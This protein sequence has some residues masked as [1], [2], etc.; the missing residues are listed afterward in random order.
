M[1]GAAAVVAGLAAIVVAVVAM[2]GGDDSPGAGTGTGNPSAG[3]PRSP[4][5]AG[6]GGD[7]L[8]RRVRERKQVRAPAFSLA[9]I[10]DGEAPV[11]AR[12]P[13]ERA[14]RTGDLDLSVLTGTPIVLQVWSSD[15]PPCRAAAR[16]GQATWER[17]GRRGVAFV[18]L[19]VDA[20]GRDAL[21]FARQYGLTHPV[22]HDP[23]A[24]S[25]RAYGVEQLPETFF[26]SATGDVVGH[27]EGSA[28]E[29]QMEFGAAAARSARKIGTEQGAGS[30][31]L[32]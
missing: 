12:A 20:R 32:R 31:P 13:I 28:S 8:A 10:Q 21:R 4:L 29:R 17:W 23:V 11:Q 9:V 26:I 3:E 30:V 7:S 14:T 22:V 25:A 5:P 1:L 16:L 15:C 19:S 2:S 6:A 27:V 18:G 24:R